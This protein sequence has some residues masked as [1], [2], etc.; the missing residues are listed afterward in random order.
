MSGHLVGRVDTCAW[1]YCDTDRVT[2][3]PI[4]GVQLV[5]LVRDGEIDGFT[6]VY[7]HP[8][9]PPYQHIQ[10]TGGAWKK[11][12]DV[13][14]LKERLRENE[15][16]GEEKGQSFTSP[17]DDDEKETAAKAA[18][19]AEIQDVADEGKGEK[20]RVRAQEG[21]AGRSDKKKQ[22][23]C[24]KEKEKRAKAHNWIYISGLPPD[25]S[26][27]EVVQHFTKVGVL[28]INPATQTPKFKLYRDEQ[29]V[30]KGDA[31]LCYLR[32]ESVDM[33]LDV[34]HEGCLRPDCVLTVTRADFSA[35]SSS[36]GAATDASGEGD[37]SRNSA[38][39]GGKRAR[40]APGQLKVMQAAHK[41]TLTW[42]EDDDGGGVRR[43]DQLTI[44]VLHHAFDQPYSA[45]L[46][47]EEQR[48]A[49][50]AS[51]ERRVVG[52]CEPYGAIDKVTLFSKHLEGVVI[53][54]YHTNHAAYCLVEAL[55]RGGGDEKSMRASYWDGTT[56][57]SAEPGSTP[58][59]QQPEESPPQENGEAGEDD[60]Y[61]RW[62]EADEELPEELRVR[63]E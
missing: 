63:T 54:R 57:Y 47:S 55:G 41:Q 30:P 11:V 44:V 32:S 31:S 19:L 3:G 26:E 46:P 51:V 17:P 21:D 24:G 62:L 59:S 36:S 25:V 34:L 13:E 42:N 9:P 29:G 28:A 6:L 48:I 50:F 37:T 43:R 45:S 22:S 15:D 7:A 27:E 5:K 49:Y 1:V 18:Y 38:K 39:N 56:D 40:V 16:A 58:A 4:S 52:L 61:S 2:H 12:S 10:L 14:A 20:K 53:V 33:A 8:C 35:S 60:E 23:K